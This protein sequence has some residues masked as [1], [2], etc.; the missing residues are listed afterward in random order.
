MNIKNKKIVL[1]GCTGN[2]GKPIYD[3]LNKNENQIIILSRNCPNFLNK[4]QLKNFFKMDFSKEIDV[5]KA[6]NFVKKKFKYPDLV[7]NGAYTREKK[8]NEKD[9]LKN[10]K[11]N[12]VGYYLINKLFADYMKKNKKGGSIVIIN[13]I[14]STVAP[15]F[16]LYK[17]ERYSPTADYN[18]IKGGLISQ[19][20]FFATKYGKYNIRFNSISYGGIKNK[21]VDKKFEKIYSLRVPLGR[22]MFG[23]EV[24]GI[25]L[26]LASDHS[27]Y[28][29]GNNIFVD[30]GYTCL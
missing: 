17:N 4:E 29:T 15:N 5:K 24:G 13:S 14:Y 25:L 16:K 1:I 6:I 30:G 20:K 18:F 22:M 19:T 8:I 12:A 26:F 21:I 28:I 11:K 9:L 23:E 27:S 7:V 3:F 10:I 2:L